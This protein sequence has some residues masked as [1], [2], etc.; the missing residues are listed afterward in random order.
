M[1]ADILEISQVSIQAKKTFMVASLGKLALLGKNKKST[2]P[3][4][5]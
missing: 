5:F 4:T 3:K 2:P 1:V